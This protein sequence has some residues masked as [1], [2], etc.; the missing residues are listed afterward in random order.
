MFREGRI[1]FISRL[2][3]VIFL[4]FAGDRLIH[5]LVR[6][7]FLTLLLKEFDFCHDLY[8]KRESLVYLDRVEFLVKG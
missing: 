3:H 4:K 8:F 2:C 6:F 1:I 7:M 5:T